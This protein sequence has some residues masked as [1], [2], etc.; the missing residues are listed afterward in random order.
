MPKPGKLYLVPMNLGESINELVIPAGVRAKAITIQHW[1]AESAKTSRRFLRDIGTTI[2]LNDLL[3]E[4]LNK[5]TP[6]EAIERMLLPIING[7][8]LG[9][10]SEAGCPAVAD[11]GA[12][13]VEAAH[14]KGIQ[15]V[16]F[17]G[18]SS[19][20]LTLMAS[21][22]NGQQFAFHGYLPIDKAARKKAIQQMEAESRQHNRTQL[23]IETPFRNDALLTDCIQ[24]L[25][26]AS[27]LCIGVDLTLESEFIRSQ[28][29]LDWRK[30]K[31]E[32]IHKRLAVFALY[33]GK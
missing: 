10:M 5:H 8:D 26:P 3:F 2:P 12:L 24:I 27:R 30:Q 11:P 4:E 33:A 18:P 1:V 23:F 17:T 22:F 29:V 21:G 6:P 13:L 14:R 9:L 32:S 25:N 20:L 28:T 15:V 16:P 7:H 19:I 31:P